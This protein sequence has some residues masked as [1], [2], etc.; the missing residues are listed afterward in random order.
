LAVEEFML[1]RLKTYQTS[2]GFYDLAIAAPSMK[3][4]LEAW[5]TTRNLF[6]Q[7]Y[8]KESEDSEA[9]AATMSKPGVVLQRPVGSDKPFRE[10]AELPTAASLGAGPGKT[11]PP[12]RSLGPAKKGAMVEASARPLPRLRRRTGSEKSV[13]ER[14]RQ[15]PRSFAL[16]SRRQWR[17]LKPHSRMGGA[18]TTR[19]PPKYSGIAPIDR[20]A[21]EENKRWQKLQIRLEAAVRKA[22]E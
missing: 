20:R 3:A 5:G 13:A 8:A 16:V 15:L 12:P 14:E 4:A 2:Q 9:I 22:G 18:S 1:R 6:H 11:K 21:A 7:G 17:R 10:H 19:R